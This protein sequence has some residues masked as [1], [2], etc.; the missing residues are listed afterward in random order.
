MIHP[1]VLPLDS[2]RA[3]RVVRSFAATGPAIDSLD[4]ELLQDIAEGLGRSV[5]TGQLPPGAERRWIRLL[6]TRSYDA[7]LIGW[8]PGTGLDLHDHGESS[9]APYVVAGVLDECHLSARSPGNAVTRRLVGGDALAF[10]SAHVHAMHN[11][12]DA[13]AL[14]V[15]V[16]SPPLS[17]MTFFEPGA[18]AQLLPLDAALVDPHHE[19][20]PLARSSV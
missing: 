6:R 8:P 14:S 19:S 13:E 18:G 5:N 10:D 15:H 4:C 9:A 20:A 2:E 17:T 1:S 12:N 16:Y 3:R 11:S 7:W